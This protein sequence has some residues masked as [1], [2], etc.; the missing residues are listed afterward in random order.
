MA[1]FKAIKVREGLGK[2]KA[3]EDEARPHRAYRVYDD[4]GTFLG[5]TYISQ[6]ANKDIDDYLL[7]LMARQLKI[8]LSLWKAIIKCTK[9]R[10]EYIAMAKG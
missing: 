8:P 9:G 7:G 3:E 2:L 6:G 10:L 1:V 5:E 4:D